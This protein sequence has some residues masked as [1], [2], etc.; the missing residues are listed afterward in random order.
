MTWDI[1]SYIYS[2]KIRLKIVEMLFDNVMIPK[3]LSEELSY[4]MSHVSRALKELETKGIV[5][6]LTPER[7]KGRLYQITPTGKIIVEKIR[8]IENI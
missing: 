2:S 1:I 6:C 4:A 3:Q 5:S 7:H 8:E